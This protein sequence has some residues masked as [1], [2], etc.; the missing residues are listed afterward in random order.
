LDLNDKCNLRCSMCYFFDGAGTSEMKPEVFSRIVDDVL[1]RAHT[2]Y[3]SCGA[4]PF[5]SPGFIPA[6]ER[7][8]RSGV[9]AIH[10]VSNGL[11]LSEKIIKALLDNDVEMLEVS[12]DGATKDTYESIRIGGRF[13]TLKRNLEALRK[14]KE[15][16]GTARPE[17]RFRWVLMRRNLHE[18]SELIDL[19]HEAGA[20]AVGLQHLVM[21]NPAMSEETISTEALRRECDQA[22]R[23]A[24]QKAASLGIEFAAP[25]EFFKPP[26]RFQDWFRW[27]LHEGIP[28]RLQRLRNGGQTETRYKQRCF[29]PWQKVYIN[30]A[31]TVTPCPVW[32]DAPLGSLAVQDF[33]GIWNGP[34]YSS[35]RQELTCGSLRETCRVC[36][37]YHGDTAWL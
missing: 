6:L 17:L 14:A 21:H 12:L 10:I 36:P 4:E 18:V 3:L 7:T 26:F 29:E 1:P 20:M 8:H 34:G 19:A 9:P 23:A 2:V 30:H 16:R 24:R 25:P 37:I 32:N 31:G 15:A 22:V 35:L 27:Q 33:T 11:L 28:R 5:M 13:E